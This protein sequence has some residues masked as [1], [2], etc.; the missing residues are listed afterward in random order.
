MKC[1]PSMKI[2]AYKTLQIQCV[3]RWSPEM[4]PTKPRN[5]RERPRRSSGHCRKTPCAYQTSTAADSWAARSSIHNG[6]KSSSLNR[7]GHS[8]SQLSRQAA[9][10]STQRTY[11]VLVTPM[12]GRDCTVMD[13]GGGPCSTARILLGLT[14]LRESLGFCNLRRSHP[15]CKFI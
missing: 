4:T 2:L 10:H 6:S 5:W 9:I 14:T 15:A 1:Q 12:P 7:R 3:R 13:G 11:L 8:G